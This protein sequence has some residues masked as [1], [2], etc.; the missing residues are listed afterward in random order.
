[1]TIVAVLAF[2]E[3][4]GEKDVANPFLYEQSYMT[5]CMYVCTPR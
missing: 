4:E 2:D 5:L 3:E 1:M